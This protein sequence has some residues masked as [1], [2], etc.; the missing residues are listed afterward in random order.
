M[1]EI[2]NCQP[3]LIRDATINSNY[4]I[5]IP[6]GNWSDFNRDMREWQQLQNH[7][8]FCLSI[9]PKPNTNDYPTLSAT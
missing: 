7:P 5:L 6:S 3:G 4:D 2:D 9:V 8:F 1:I